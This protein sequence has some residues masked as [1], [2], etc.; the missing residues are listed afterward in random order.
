MKFFIC[1]RRGF[2]L[3]EIMLVVI[4]IA[5]LS[6]MVVPRLVGRSDQAKVS[7]AKS[8]IE[9]NLA[10]ALRLF[11]LDNG[12]FPTTTQGLEALRVR[13]AAPPTPRNWNGPY[14]E[15]D[16][17]DPWGNPYVY[18]SPGKHR[19]DYDLYSKG[20]DASSPDDDIKNWE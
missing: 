12:F 1:C 20:R 7:V 15:K 10:T 4:I 16:P 2:T 3:I 9:G 18:E 13:P 6:A 5:A 17:V 11:E 8:D 14:I 19:P